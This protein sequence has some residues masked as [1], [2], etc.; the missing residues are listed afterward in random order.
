MTDLNNLRAMMDFYNKNVVGPSP[1]YVDTAG[2]RMDQNADPNAGF[3]WAMQQNNAS[4]STQTPN[5]FAQATQMPPQQAPEQQ[6]QGGGGGHN[7]YSPRAMQ[8]DVAP[9]AADQMRGQTTNYLSQLLGQNGSQPM[10]SFD[11]QMGNWL[12]G[13]G[14][15]Y[16]GRDMPANRANAP[17][18]G[19]R[20]Y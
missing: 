8:L 20:S 1:S 17:G 14:S 10:Q 4:N 19:M 13:N 3:R 7:P 18:A 12:P 2:G 9:F 11:A 15:Q 6:P 16:G 5:F